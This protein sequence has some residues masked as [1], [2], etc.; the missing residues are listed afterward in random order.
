MEN[1][2]RV[3]IA[4]SHIQ[5]SLMGDVGLKRNIFISWGELNEKFNTLIH[6]F[7]RIPNL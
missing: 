4:L 5:P 3:A 2:D 1:A 7:L 6:F